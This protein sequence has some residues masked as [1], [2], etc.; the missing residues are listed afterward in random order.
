MNMEITIIKT[1]CDIGFNLFKKQLFWPFFI[2]ILAISYEKYLATL[3]MRIISSFVTNW[4]FRRIQSRRHGGAL[5][6]FAPPD[7]TPRP[8]N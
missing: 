5:A 1:F 4:R 3:N 7:K 8:L 2:R 6:G